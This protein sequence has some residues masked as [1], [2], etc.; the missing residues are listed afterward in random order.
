MSSSNAVVAR[1]VYRMMMRH[2]KH[3]DRH[4]ARKA[5][6]GKRTADRISVKTR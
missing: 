5:V 1:Y 3:F 6:S 2:A 4:Q